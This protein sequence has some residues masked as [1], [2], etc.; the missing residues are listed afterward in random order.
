MSIPQSRSLSI[1]NPLISLQSQ[2]WLFAVS[3][4]YWTVNTGLRKVR[5]N[6][7]LGELCTLDCEH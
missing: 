4:V 2:E 6:S 1:Q 5:L 7:G 3:C